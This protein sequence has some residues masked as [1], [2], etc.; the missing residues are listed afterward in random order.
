[1]FRSAFASREWV[2]VDRGGW[3]LGRIPVPEEMANHP[4]TEA[5]RDPLRTRTIMRMST[6]ALCFLASLTGCTFTVPER[7]IESTVH[8][9]KDVAVTPNQLRLR[10]RSLVGP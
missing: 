3:D 9:Q 2:P 4:S 7:K 1:C 5:T 10:M 6:A 8:A